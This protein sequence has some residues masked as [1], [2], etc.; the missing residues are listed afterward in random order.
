[1]TL[2]SNNI[3][4]CGPVY[5][6]ERL[7]MAGRYAHMSFLEG[8]RR[9]GSLGIRR[10]TS[11]APGLLSGP[12][13][14]RNRP[15]YMGIATSLTA[16]S[17]RNPTETR[18]ERADTCAPDVCLAALGR[19]A[20]GPFLLR[21]AV[22]RSGSEQRGEMSCRVLLGGSAAG[23]GCHAAMGRGA[24]VVQQHGPG[25]RLDNGYCD[26]V[27]GEG[28]DRRGG[29]PQRVRGQL[30][31]AVSVQVAAQQV[32]ALE[33]GQVAQLGQQRASEVPAVVCGAVG[34]GRRG[35]GS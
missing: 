2:A 18:A 13:P 19:R 23:I 33:T 14:L 24:I 9:P 12:A 16:N 26:V 30:D 10:R 25:F 3:R 15:P 21:P 27:P 8:I 1:M 22:Y 35:P 11:Q 5:G 20:F 29:F 4:I 7:V 31:S 32:R 17:S 6:T 34:V 28:A